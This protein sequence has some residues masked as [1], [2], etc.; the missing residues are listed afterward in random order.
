MGAPDYEGAPMGLYLD[1]PYC[2]QILVPNASSPL[3][4][5]TG[6]WYA[7]ACM[8]GWY[9]EVG[10]RQGVPEL[11]SSQLPPEIQARIGFTGHMATGSANAQVMMQNYGG[12]QSE[13]DLLAN[14]EHLTAVR[15]CEEAAYNFNFVELEG[16]LRRFGPIF[17]YW[18]KT[19]NGKTYGHASVLVGCEEMSP[20]LIYH[21]PENAPHSRMTIADFNAKRQRWRYA[22]MRKQ[23]VAHQIR[24]VR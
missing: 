1:V 13:H 20:E 7:S 2:S 15:H 16:L 3:N 22:M 4:D 6:C 12:G 9:F 11:H 19:A 14:R 23:G 17:F 21:D 18:Q 8:V 10:P 5:P 24:I